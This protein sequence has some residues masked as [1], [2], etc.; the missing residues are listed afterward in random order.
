MTCCEADMTLTGIICVYPE[1]YKL[2]NKEWVD[3]TGIIRVR[4]DETLKRDI[5]VC[6]VVELKKSETSGREIITLV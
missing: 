6:R 2:Q 1:A 4:Y 5:P 3:V